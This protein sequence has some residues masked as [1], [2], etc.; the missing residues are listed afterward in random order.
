M[1][2][3]KRIVALLEEHGEAS[4]YELIQFVSD[5]PRERIIK[6][7]Q[8]A[9]HLGYVR[10]T[11][12]TERRGKAQ[13]AGIWIAVR[14]PNDVGRPSSSRSSEE[15]RAIPPPQPR[16]PVSSVWDLGRR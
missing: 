12:L 10:C 16:L 5:Q 9:S 15:G 4:T 13:G 8:N 1:S 11:G 7:V 3:M 6:A 2:L 14:E